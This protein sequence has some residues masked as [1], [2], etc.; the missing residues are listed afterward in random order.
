M[1]G[2]QTSLLSY[3]QTAVTKHNSACVAFRLGQQYDYINGKNGLFCLFRL[4]MW[5]KWKQRLK[6]DSKC[7]NIEVIDQNKRGLQT[8]SN[9]QASYGVIIRLYVSHNAVLIPR[10]HS[11]TSAVLYTAGLGSW[12][13]TS[14]VQRGTTV[15][16]IGDELTQNHQGDDY[17]K[18]A[19]FT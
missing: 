11:A 1:S 17:A 7:M 15:L 5:L 18:L 9:P 6:N 3:K 4:Q 12:L 13:P 2:L 16:S 19:A 14:A 10:Y 8:E